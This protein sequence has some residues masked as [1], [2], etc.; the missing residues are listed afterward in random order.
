MK[1]HHLLPILFVASFLPV[2][3]AADPVPSVDQLQ[4]APLHQPQTLMQEGAAAEKGPVVVASWNIEWFPTK[5]PELPMESEA[6]EKHIGAIAA[7]IKELNPTIMIATEVRDVAS[8][9]KLDAGFTHLACTAI[10]RPEDENPDLPN[11]GIALL[12]KL[13]WD[14]VWA[15]D[16]SGLP[17]TPDRPSRGILGAKIPLPNGKPLYVYGVHLKSNRGGVEAA[18]VRRERAIDYWLAD[19]RRWRLDPEK[20]FIVIMGDFNSSP[21]DPRFA[22]DKTLSKVQAAGFVLASDGMTPEQAVTIPASGQYPAN[23]FDHI[24]L[25][26]ALAATMKTPAPWLEIESVP[27]SLS[28]HYPIRVRLDGLE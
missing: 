15:L 1:L 26:K 28:D 17:Q 18:A 2:A 4:P 3:Q 5:R 9:G 7:K 16:F 27:K 20:D 13:P 19:L 23:D 14:S 8:L 11:Q 22:P 6:V 12:S 21:R 25:S 24:L 10:P